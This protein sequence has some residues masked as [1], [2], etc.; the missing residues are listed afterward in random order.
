MPLG[1]SSSSIRA[2]VQDPS[3]SVTSMG[4]KLVMSTSTKGTT[5][6]A[7]RLTIDNAVRVSCCIF[8]RGV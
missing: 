6:L 1:S 8:L 5:D 3:P 4:G 2:D 7:D